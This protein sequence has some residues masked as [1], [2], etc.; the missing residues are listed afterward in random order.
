MP[1]LLI[2]CFI[3]LMFFL[4]S[5]REYSFFDLFHYNAV[6]FFTPAEFLQPF[7]LL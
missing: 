5:I 4:F 3:T 7:I 6:V 1:L 2:F